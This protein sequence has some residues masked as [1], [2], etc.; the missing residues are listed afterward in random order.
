[1][2]RFLPHS[3]SSAQMSICSIP[4]P[5]KKHSWKQFPQALWVKY[6]CAAL[7]GSASKIQ[8]AKNVFSFLNETFKH[9]DAFALLREKQDNL[10]PTMS[11]GSCA[12]VIEKKTKVFSAVFLNKIVNG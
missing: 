1:M 12:K 9:K 11:T 10:I 3:H 6:S 7:P 5:G 8:K 2:E 4:S